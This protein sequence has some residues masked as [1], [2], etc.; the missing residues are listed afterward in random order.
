MKSIIGAIAPTIVVW[1]IL[2][3]ATNG[4]AASE[5]RVTNMLGPQAQATA[6]VSIVNF[7]FQPDT[8]TIKVNDAVRW[9]NNE[10]SPI[11][12]TSTSDTGL[13]GSSPLSSGDTFTHT[14]TT[15][16]YFAYHCA[17]HPSMVGAVRVIAPSYF[18]LITHP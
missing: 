2:A 14:F 9:T 11:M 4:H 5:T 1:S 17:I 8:L 16:G 13:W 6:D 10:Q 7:S 15:T 12:H 3:L 18:P